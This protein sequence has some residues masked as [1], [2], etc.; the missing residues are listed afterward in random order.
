MTIEYKDSK[1]IVALSGTTTEST[2]TYSSDVTTCSGDNDRNGFMVNSTSSAIYGKT[3]NSVSFYLKKTGSPTGTAYV[4]V[5]SGSNSGSGTQVHEFG[6]IDVSTLTTSYV[7]Y[8]F[9]TGSHT[10]AVNDTVGLQYSGSTSNAPVMQGATSDVYD[11]TNTIRN[12]FTS[13]AFSPVTS[14]DMRFEVLEGDVK[15]TNVQDNS[16]LVEKDTGKRYWFN[17]TTWTMEPTYENNFSSSTGWTLP[18]GAT[19]SGNKLSLTNRSDGTTEAR[20][21]YRDLSADIGQTYLSDTWLLRFKISGTSLTNSNSGQAWEF[22]VN[23][24]DVA[25]YTGEN[26]SSGANGGGFRLALHGAS[27]NGN[28]LAQAW[29]NNNQQTTS[30]SSFSNPITLIWYIELIFN[31]TKIITK[32]YNNS[33]YSD[34]PTTVEVTVTDPSDLEGSLKYLNM[35]SYVQG[36]T[37]ASTVNVEDIKFYDGVTSV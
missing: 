24:S 9:N 3:I 32:Q 26:P 1:R 2:G 13:G 22:S 16:I 37:T 6:T 5:W 7:K 36:I 33:D 28:T 4:R 17:G 29:S 21:V 19:I 34:T 31:G 15:P 25:S 18:T 23:L 8:T 14:H 35:R 20:N 27:S 12:R 11:G 30:S 10:L